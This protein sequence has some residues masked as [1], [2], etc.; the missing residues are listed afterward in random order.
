MK[1]VEL[2]GMPATGKTFAINS[3]KK[4]AYKKE[5]KIFIYFK[6]RSILS[7]FF[8]LKFIFF[9]FFSIIKSQ[10][11]RNTINF[12]REEYRPKKSKL[13][14]LRTLSIIFNTI[15]LISLTK[16]YGKERINK[17][18]YLDQGFFQILFSIIYEMDL[19]NKRDLENVIT[20]WVQNL[21]SINQKICLFYCISK[22]EEIIK[23]LLRRK[24]DS[25]IEKKE[26]NKEDLKIYKNIFKIIVNFLTYQKEKYPNINLKII[27]LN[28]GLNELLKFK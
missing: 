6:K 9:S 1:I 24:G 5:D 15:F 11:L 16:I 20:K 28:D 23:R 22:D 4:K 25:I 3:L 17:G 14:S 12:F 21:S 7:I 19:P 8:K 27:D 2:F 10:T 26:I 13:L 18:I